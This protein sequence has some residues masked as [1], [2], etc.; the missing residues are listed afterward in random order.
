MAD[1]ESPATLFEL[2]YLFFAFLGV[3]R[4]IY[5]NACNLLA[6]M[7]N[8]APVWA[9]DKEVYIDALH[10]KGHT[11][12][13]AS[14]STGVPVPATCRCAHCCDRLWHLYGSVLSPRCGLHQ[15]STLQGMKE[16]FAS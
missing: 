4:L 12:C 9:A 2:L 1:S 14:F 8:R 16:S 13:A 6:Y 7:L 10:A 5:D 11:G 15:Q 3:L